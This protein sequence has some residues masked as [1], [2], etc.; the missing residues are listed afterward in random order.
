MKS[1]KIVA[2]TVGHGPKTKKIS[3][4]LLFGCDGFF[5]SKFRAYTCEIQHYGKFGAKIFESVKQ[6]CVKLI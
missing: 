3:L 6:K 4:T 5:A 2:K 1:L